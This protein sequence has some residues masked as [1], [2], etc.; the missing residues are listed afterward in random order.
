MKSVTVHEA[1]THLSKLVAAV[2]E[3]EEVI[4]CRGQ[5]PVARIVPLRS[6]PRARPR[7]G[8]VTSA[9]VSY[10]EDCFLPVTDEEAAEWGLR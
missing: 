10:T 6:R 1:K 3:G 4:V 7:V 9:P 5:E 8:E 2:R